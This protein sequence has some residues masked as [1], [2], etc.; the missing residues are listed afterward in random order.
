MNARRPADG[1]AVSSRSQ[2]DP[3]LH[4]DVAVARWSPVPSSSHSCATRP[5][6]RAALTRSRPGLANRILLWRTAREDTQPRLLTCSP[7]AS[8]LSPPAPFSP[9]AAWSR[10]VF[11]TSRRRGLCLA[12]GMLFWLSVLPSFPCQS[13]GIWAVTAVT[14]RSKWLDSRIEPATGGTIARLST[15]ADKLPY[16]EGEQIDFDAY[17]SLS[18]TQK[19]LGAS[20]VAGIQT[21][22]SF[23]AVAPNSAPADGDT[24]NPSSS[25]FRGAPWPS[26]RDGARQDADSKGVTELQRTTP[27]KKHVLLENES[28]TQAVTRNTDPEG[29]QKK[30]HHVQR[31]TTAEIISSAQAAAQVIGQ[32]VEILREMKLKGFGHNKLASKAG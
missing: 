10:F 24:E 18:T 22:A 8:P 9:E 30:E 32:S 23:M 7:S 17:R 14:P 5:R 21:E 31:L 2:P 28:K 11:S 16:T 15:N 4:T 25:N 20:A 27:A 19:E 12:L 1:P 6:R 26:Q 3:R 29:Q 13:N